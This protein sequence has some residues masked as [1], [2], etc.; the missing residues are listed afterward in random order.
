MPLLWS[1]GNS[2]EIKKKVNGFDRYGYRLLPSVFF[3]KSLARGKLAIPGGIAD[4]GGGGG[5]ATSLV[6]VYE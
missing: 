1:I 2:F 4:A 6:R 5:N 3:P